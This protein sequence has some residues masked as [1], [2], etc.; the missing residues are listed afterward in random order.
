MEPRSRVARTRRHAVP[1]LA[2]LF[3]LGS[4]CGG[5]GGGGG[6]GGTS[7]PPAGSSIQ[8]DYIDVWPA[9]AKAA[10]AYAVERWNAYLVSPVAI[11]CAAYW[12]PLFVFEGAVASPELTYDAS[13]TYTMAQYNALTSSDANGAAYEM[14]IS[15]NSSRSDWYLGTDG[16]PPPAERDLVT[17]VMHEIAHGLGWMSTAVESSG[18][19]SFGL[20]VGWPPSRYDDLL[21]TGGG[22]QIVG[23]YANGTAAL[24]AVLTSDDVEFSGAQATSA[25]AGLH[26]EIYA[27]GTWVPGSS[28]SH[29]A[30]AVFSG[31]ADLLMTPTLPAGVAAHDLGP[32]TMGVLRDLGWTLP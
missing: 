29:L 3:L 27:P 30:P 14:S 22:V 1:F 21:A 28:I 9:D 26:P 15:C 17:A 10:F 2:F 32:V 4:A 19:A 12:I 20:G 24:L 13:N 8:V 25:N 6:S 11:R 18:T 7:P 31:T 5:G 23:N 16:N